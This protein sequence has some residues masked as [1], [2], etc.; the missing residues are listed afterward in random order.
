[1]CFISSCVSVHTLC[2]SS[3]IGSSGEITFNNV[4]NGYH[5]LRV[6]AG[7]EEE[8]IRNRVIIMSDNP[9]FCSLNA[10]NQGVT[11]EVSENGTA[12]ATLEFRPIGKD[13]GFYCNL[14]KTSEYFSCVLLCLSPYVLLNF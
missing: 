13:V 11:T 7:T 6:I 2:V 8:A 14:N 4:T 1:M 10:I 12:E 3:S 5:R 9:E